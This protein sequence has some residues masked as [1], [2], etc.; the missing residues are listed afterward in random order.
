MLFDLRAFEALVYSTLQVS[1]VGD[2][3]QTHF[4]SS[5][6]YGAKVSVVFELECSDEAEKTRVRECPS[7]SVSRRLRHHRQSDES[8]AKQSRAITE[9]ALDN[10]HCHVSEWCHFTHVWGSVFK[11]G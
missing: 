10:W 9:P 7:S 1:I 8:K 3:A 2:L 6:T 4:V 5:I 11:T